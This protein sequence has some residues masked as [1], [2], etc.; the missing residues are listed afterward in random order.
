MKNLFLSFAVI[1]AGL[2][3]FSCEPEN[4]VPDNNPGT[5]EPKFTPPSE[6]KFVSVSEDFLASISETY[7]F[8]GDEQPITFT[9][10]NGV[11]VNISCLY[12]VDGTP[13]TD[14]VDVK[15]VGLFDIGSMAVAN[16]PLLGVDPNDP[17]KKAP[18]VTGG[19]FKLEVTTLDGERVNTCFYYVNVP[20]SLSGAKL[21]DGEYMTLWQVP[22][23]AEDFTWE[24]IGAGQ[25]GGLEGRICEGEGDGSTKGEICQYFCWLQESFKWTNIDWL[26][27]LGGEPVKLWVYVP[28]GFDAT[29][30]GVYAAYL[31]PA[32]TLAPF[33][34]WDKDKGAFTE[35]TGLAPVGYEMYVVFIS[36][37]LKSQK[38]LYGLKKITVPDVEEY[39]ITFTEDDLKVATTDD[40]IKAIN[41]TLAGK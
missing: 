30:C 35:H 4:E 33:D 19:E 9:T 20:T 23:D 21:P 22:E 37:D 2:M 1:C 41:D 40:V 24:G 5:V 25:E 29:N 10:E 3:M 31:E 34:V 32:N 12:S 15:Y 8:K 13:I 18:L 36:F 14:S 11:E 17:S 6:D 38:V 39:E 28:E 7:R 27:S 16:K 26:M